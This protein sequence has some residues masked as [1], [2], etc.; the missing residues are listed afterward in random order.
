MDWIEPGLAI[1]NLDDAMADTALRDQG[2]R[3]VVTLNEFPSYPRRGFEWRCV[4]L[5][6]GGGNSVADYSEALLCVA[7]FHDRMPGVLVHCAEGK[8]R[9]VVIVALYLARARGWTPEDALG[10]V[11]RRRTVALPDDILWKQARA[12]YA[13]LGLAEPNL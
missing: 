10:H 1:G 11:S 9:S 12:F 4:P 8:S 2:I 13:G 3:S 7:D 5:R 6:D